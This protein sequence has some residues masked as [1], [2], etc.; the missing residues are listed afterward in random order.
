MIVSV[1]RISPRRMV[2]DFRPVS[3]WAYRIFGLV[4]IAAG[5]TVALLLAAS[6]SFDCSRFSGSCRYRQITPLG[7]TDSLFPVEELRGGRVGTQTSGLVASM[8]LYVLTR[9]SELAIPLVTADGAAKDSLA[10]A[11]TH[12]A[13]DPTQ[14]EVQIVEDRRVIGYVFGG[15]LVGAG[16][17]C[18]LAIERVRL[19]FDRDKGL[20]QLKRR[21]WMWT[22]GVRAKLERVRDVKMREHRFR[23]TSGWSVTIILKDGSELPLT[24]RPLFTAIS[25]QHAKELIARWLA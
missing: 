19:I 16:L 23:R 8:T 14:L 4:F 9:H 24:A 21:R 13:T 25:A 12:Y 22:R 11:L 3:V 2:L 1:R 10:G 15:F 17:L 20:L 7:R 5:V 18:L 6:V